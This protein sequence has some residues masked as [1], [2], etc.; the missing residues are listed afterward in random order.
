[1]GTDVER[2]FKSRYG[3][4]AL[5]RAAAIVFLVI[6]GLLGLV[7]FA[8]DRNARASNEHQARTDL[9]SAARVAAADVSTIRANLRAQAAEAASSPEVQRAVLAGD[10]KAIVAAAR[11]HHAQIQIG[12]RMLGISLTGIQMHGSATIADRGHE[13]ARVVVGVELDR[14]FLDALAYAAPV[15]P[16]SAL[17]LVRDG[18]VLAGGPAGAKA[19]LANGRL[20][21]LGLT[22]EAERHPLGVART[23]V[24]A[25]EP[26]AA[27]QAAIAPFR[28]RLFLAAAL[29]LALAA[30]VAARLARPAARMLADLSHLRRQAETDG[31]TSIANRRKF[32]E[33]LD[34]EIEHARRLSTNVSLVLADIDNFKSINDTHGH[35]V[36]DAVIKAV[37]EAFASSVRDLDLV[38]RFGGEEFAAVL[39]GTNLIGARRLAERVRKTVEAIVVETGDGRR[40]TVTASFG[41][42]AFPTYS[43]PGALIAAADLGLYDA[44]AGGKNCVVTASAKDG[45]RV[46][47]GALAS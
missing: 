30:A 2:R 25:V 15:P 13:L 47:A 16:G 43:T 17:L 34:E 4:F 42:G 41:V 20:A 6:A 39:P 38:A 37:A 18:R 24:V 14:S 22:F 5:I 10:P 36:G 28:R 11:A 46:A 1:M 45:A 7:L 3:R 33:R 23:D 31:L 40:V 44:K 29:T 9:A 32:D 21:I 8:V 27:V 19:V 26:V 12:S 35:Q